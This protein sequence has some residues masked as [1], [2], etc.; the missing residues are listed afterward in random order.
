MRPYEVAQSGNRINRDSNSEVL[1]I[2]IQRCANT[3]LRRE[4]LQHPAL[5]FEVELL[6]VKIRGTMTLT[7]VIHKP[8]C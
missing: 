4:N 1:L 3:K 8:H 7:S 6:R 5:A 2:A